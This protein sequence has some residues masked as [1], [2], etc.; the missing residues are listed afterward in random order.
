MNEVEA[1]IT[2]PLH[3]QPK[4]GA[5]AFMM[6]DLKRSNGPAE[7][8]LL[9]AVVYFEG[10]F[11]VMDQESSVLRAF[12][13]APGAEGIID[14]AAIAGNA[15][16]GFIPEI[17]PESGRGIPVGGCKVTEGANDTP[18]ECLTG[19]AKPRGDAAQGE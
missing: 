3:Q 8:A 11:A 6:R 5:S 15:G 16:F 18:A 13:F 1:V 17:D 14:G 9:P 7:D 12:P 4:E 2:V 10:R 19:D